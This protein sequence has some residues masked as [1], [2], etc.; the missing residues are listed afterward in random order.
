HALK[1]PTSPGCTGICTRTESVPA[2]CNVCSDLEY[3]TQLQAIKTRA[4]WRRRREGERLDSLNYAYLTRSQLIDRAKFHYVD[5]KAFR[6]QSKHAEKRRQIVVK[7]IDIHKRI[8]M[9]VGSE[10]IGGIKRIF[11]QALREGKSVHAILA[12]LESAVNRQYSARNYDRKDLHLATVVMRIGGPSL[13]DT[14]HQAAG[15]PS[16][17][18]TQ[19]QLRAGKVSMAVFSNW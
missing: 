8:V 18:W 1:N 19:K 15:M 7:N 11:G 6:L 13:L 4:V 5:K 9:M 3:N 14:L 16:V 2:P 10:D 17:S 12:T